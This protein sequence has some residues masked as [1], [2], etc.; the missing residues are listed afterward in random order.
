M[1]SKTSLINRTEVEINAGINDVNIIPG[2]TFTQGILSH[3]V[4]ELCQW[5]LNVLNGHMDDRLQE[6]VSPNRL[7]MLLLL[8]LF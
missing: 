6:Q 2:S 8:H 3:T 5:K 7:P 4:R 1:S